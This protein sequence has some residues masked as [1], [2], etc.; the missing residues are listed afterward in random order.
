M[1]S[2]SA[3]MIGITAAQGLF[4]MQSTR[5]QAKAQASYYSAQADA[6]R[7]NAR[8]ADVQRGQIADQYFQRQQQLD[9]RRRLT[10]ASNRAETGASGLDGT[11][12]VADMAS[13]INDEWR[14]QSMNLLA[15]QR[16]DTKS[17]YINQVN[18][19]N[20]AN[21]ADA[22]AYNAKA[23]GRSA[24][25]GTLLSTAL[26]VYGSA[27]ALRSAGAGNTAPGLHHVPSRLK[28]PETMEDQV[29]GMNGN[30]YRSKTL[31]YGARND[32]YG[33]LRR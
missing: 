13:S 8:I 2:L 24:M 6:A 21:A 18:Y 11:G 31:T 15:N 23:Q 16:N 27:R 33:W 9:A 30:S 26:S 25:L 17:A 4:Q 5:Q 20:Q 3:A 10:L 32:P 19:E 12:S 22:S 1:C 14:N 7:Q 28:V 29:F